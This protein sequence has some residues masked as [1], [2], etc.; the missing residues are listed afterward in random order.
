MARNSFNTEV[1]NLLKEFSG[2]SN[3]EFAD[4][5]GKRRPNMCNYLRGTCVPGRRVLKSAMEH[6]YEWSIRPIKEVEPVPQDLKTLPTDSGIYIFYDSGGNV[7]YIGRANNLRFEV[8]QTL[9]RRIPVAIRV[10]PKLKKKR[11]TMREL[12]QSL[13][14]YAVTSPRLRHNLEVILLRI[15]ANQTH[16]S[17]IGEF[18]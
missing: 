4:A 11:P 17:N 6:L 9:R 15:F 2:L 3:G 13:S 1:M 8:R 10:G 7:I 12:T 16:N 18:K 14:L 5:C